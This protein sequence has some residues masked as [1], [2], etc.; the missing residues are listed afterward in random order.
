M[1]HSLV[2]R[3]WCRWFVLNKLLSQRTNRKKETRAPFGLGTVPTY[4]LY[5]VVAKAY[6]Q[7]LQVFDEVGSPTTELMVT[8]CPCDGDHQLSPRGYHRLSPCG[9]V[10]RMWLRHRLRQKALRSFAA[11]RRCVTRWC[12]PKLLRPR[13][14]HGDQT[15]RQCVVCQTF[16]SSAWSGG[17]RGRK[18]R[19]RVAQ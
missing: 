5:D 1:Y 17:P 16:T 2:H 9:Y 8:G 19:S 12:N 15:P 13:P 4:G 7:V 18:R 10:H 14:Q 6:T 3:L 11:P